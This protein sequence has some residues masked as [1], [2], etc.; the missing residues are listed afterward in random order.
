MDVAKVD[1]DVAF[2]AM[3]TH[4]CCNNL[5]QM[6]HLF[7]R[8]KLQV[9]FS[10]Y[11]ICFTHMFVSV[12]SGCCICLQWLSCVFQVFCK[13]FRHMLQVFHL[14]RTYVA[15]VNFIWMLQKWIECCICCNAREER[16]GREQSPCAVWW[17]GRHLD[18]VGPRGCVKRMRGHG[19]QAQVR[20]T[21]CSLGV[22]TSRR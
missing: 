12:F 20:E 5:F 14:F 6:F 21:E 17:R 11:C 10:R 4:V 1:R 15:S 9:C 16:R 13:C 22:R 7:F 2:V 8:R 18:D 19:L 3:A